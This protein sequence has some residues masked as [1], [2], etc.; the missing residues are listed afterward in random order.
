MFMCV[1]A[2]ICLREKGL[3]LISVF[4]SSVWA[5]VMCPKSLVLACVH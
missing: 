4:E 3:F 1:H 5:Y 2:S